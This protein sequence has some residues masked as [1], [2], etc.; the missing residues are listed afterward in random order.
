MQKEPQHRQHALDRAIDGWRHRMPPR[1]ERQSER[2]KI[3]QE[4]E[5]LCR[6]ARQVTA[7]GEDLLIELL[8][9][10]RQRRRRHPFKPGQSDRRISQRNRCL[11][12]LRRPQARLWRI[13]RSRLPPEAGI[14]ARGERRRRAGEQEPAILDERDHPPRPD[15]DLARRPHTVAL[16]VDPILEQRPAMRPVELATRRLE[17][18]E[19]GSRGARDRL[20][21][22]AAAFRR[23]FGPA[24]NTEPSS[25]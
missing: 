23:S 21:A 22:T 6:R 25:R 10:P 24:S 5:E 12:P 14:E 16:P 1:L 13:E 19:P 15:L 18:G 17:M 2:Q 9:E 4:I 8:P 7:I 11:Q 20:R 3:D